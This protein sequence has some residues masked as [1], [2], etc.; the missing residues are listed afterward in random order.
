MSLAKKK[1]NCYILLKSGSLSAVFFKLIQMEQKLEK[2]LVFL[3]SVLS[4]MS[5]PFCRLWSGGS[6]A[7]VKGAKPLKI[8][9]VSF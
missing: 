7:E 9:F 6:L 1:K 2:S 4:E 8:Y 5:D 3:L